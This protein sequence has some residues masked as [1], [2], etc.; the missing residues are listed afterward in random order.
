LINA[1]LRENWPSSAGDALSRYLTRA[2]ELRREELKLATGES[3]SLLDELSN[4][5]RGIPSSSPILAKSSSSAGITSPTPDLKK[6]VVPTL[7]SRVHSEY[8]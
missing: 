3:V 1:F 2:E 7:P 4:V 8:L 5:M 6:V